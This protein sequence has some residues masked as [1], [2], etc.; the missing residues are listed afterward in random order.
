MRLVLTHLADDVAT[1]PQLTHSADDVKK[2][3]HLAGGRGS[4]QPCGMAYDADNSKMYVSDTGIDQVFA[5][6]LN[7]LGMPVGCTSA[8]TLRLCDHRCCGP[9]AL[10]FHQG[11]STSRARQGTSLYSL[12]SESHGSNDLSARNRIWDQRDLLNPSAE[13]AR[14]LAALEASSS[15]HG[16]AEPPHRRPD[17][18]LFPTRPAV[19]CAPS[20][21]RARHPASSASPPP[22]PCVGADAWMSRLPHRR[23]RAGRAR[24]DPLADGAPGLERFTLGAG[25]AS[26]VLARGRW[27]PTC[28]PTC[29]SGRRADMCVARSKTEMCSNAD[30]ENESPLLTRRSSSRLKK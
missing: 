3:A 22:S 10:C 20:A 30:A 23:R 6:Q 18:C 15:W 25:G 19:G 28:A 2:W 17:V 16:H 9:G 13:A 14:K 24:P 29:A 27:R 5:V 26:G 4:D 11:S 8:K 12:A 1:E 21:S 7:N